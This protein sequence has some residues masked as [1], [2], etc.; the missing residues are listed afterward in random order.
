MLVIM[1]DGIGLTS[2]RNIDRRISLDWK[3]LFFYAVFLKVQLKEVSR[4][5]RLMNYELMS[6][7]DLW[8][9][10]FYNRE[11]IKKFLK[12]IALNQI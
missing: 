4:L 7:F 1:T 5:S 8:S 2:S 9:N 12:L 11:K 10:G 3:A 6:L